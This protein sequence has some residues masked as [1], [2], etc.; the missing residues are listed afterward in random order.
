V[1]I[2]DSVESTY[3]LT[4]QTLQLLDIKMFK[5]KVWVVEQIQQKSQQ[6]QQILICPTW[7]S[8]QD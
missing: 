4:F 2:T 6:I 1:R 8:R 5:I 7:V 3:N